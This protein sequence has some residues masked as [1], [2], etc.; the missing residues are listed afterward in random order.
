MAGRRAHIGVDRFNE[1]FESIPEDARNQGYWRIKKENYGE[2]GGIVQSFLGFMNFNAMES[3]ESLKARVKDSFAVNRGPGEYYAIPCDDRKKEIKDVD[4]VKLS[5]SD[6]EVPVP[7]P[8][9]AN[10]SSASIG[11]P[12]KDTL[13]TFK[14]TQKDMAELQALKVQQK[15]M[16]Q[17][18]GDDDDEEDNVKET[19]G[20]MGGGIENLLLYRSL[21][22]GDKKE[23]GVG[24]DASAIKEII[25]DKM[26]RKLSDL[27]EALKPKQEDSEMKLLLRQ[28]VENQKPKEDSEMKELLKVLVQKSAEK[29]KES[30]L[31]TMFAMQIKQQEERDKIRESQE[32]A[33]E[34]ERR[35]E[36]ERLEAERKAE[37]EK[38]AEERK[39]E[40]ERFRA[41]QKEREE[42]FKAEMELRRQ[43]LSAAKEGSK[44]TLSDQQ[45]MQLK[46]FELM[47]DGKNSNFEVMK[48]V[49]GIMTNSGLTSMKTAQQA[50]EAIVSIAQKVKD[51]GGDAE[52]KQGGLVEILKS[53]GSIAGPV[54]GSYASADAQMKMLQNM[55]GLAGGGMGGIEKLLAGMMPQMAPQA[56]A[57][58][59]KGQA[60]PTA[61]PVPPAPRPKNV[62][63]PVSAPS[64]DPKAS[65]NKDGGMGMV[66]ASML[67]KYPEIKYTML[68]NMQENLGAELFVDFIYDFDLPGV[69]KMIAMLPPAVLMNFVKTACTDE[70]KKIIDQNLKWFEDLKRLMLEEVRSSEEEEDDEEALDEAVKDVASKKVAPK[71]QASV[72]AVTPAPA[73]TTPPPASP[74]APAAAP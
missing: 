58:A 36:R 17:L 64:A 51:T 71:A 26:D 16:K 7:T 19:S 42:R 1:F 9:D 37:R 11:D 24:L 22:D 3:Y 50:A 2:T 29:E 31:Q 53:I 48:D 72:A 60:R 69:D 73:A 35:L 41:E 8:G 47:R 57:A 21:F 70:E 74:G 38:A 25:E 18:A 34:E 59:P 43:E 52:E 23:K 62:E 6:K 45:Q 27:K 63:V 32:R 28:L 30:T 55:G 12:L 65:V 20:L 10:G 46:F 33:R 5:Y 68:G 44:A 56:P 13:N 4:M 61:V 15:L 49:F 67:Q 14:K 39:L 40:Q 66:I 54:L